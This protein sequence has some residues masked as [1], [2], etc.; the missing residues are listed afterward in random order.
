M[1]FDQAIREFADAV[2]VVAPGFALIFIRVAAMMVYA[3]LLGSVKIPKSVKV[4]VALMLSLGIA[5]GIPMPQG[6]AA[7]AVGSD[8]RHGC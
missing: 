3:P 1:S 2:Q 5:S 6:V 7:Y 4:L 8:P